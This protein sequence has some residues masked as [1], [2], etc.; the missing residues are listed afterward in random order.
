MGQISHL[1]SNLNSNIEE[2]RYLSLY[3]IYLRFKRSNR[4]K[5]DLHYLHLDEAE[6]MIEIVLKD[7]KVLLSGLFFY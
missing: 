1:N 6:Q 2:L 4:S 3:I 7:I 5:V